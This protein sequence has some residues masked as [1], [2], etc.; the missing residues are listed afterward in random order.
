MNLQQVAARVKEMLLRR[1]GEFVD[2]QLAEERA[3][4]IAQA[5]PGWMRC[6]MCGSDENGPGCA[7]CDST[8][9]AEQRYGGTR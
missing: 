5:L 4:N 9:T 1:R 7:E 2:E 3:N 6:P 8:E